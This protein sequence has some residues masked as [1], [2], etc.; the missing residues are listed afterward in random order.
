ME[1]V[2]ENGQKIYVEESLEGAVA[3]LYDENG[4]LIEQQEFSAD[5]LCDILFGD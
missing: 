4:F 5:F 1:L 2:L 3:R